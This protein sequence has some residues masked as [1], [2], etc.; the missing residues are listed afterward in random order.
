[1]LITIPIRPVVLAAFVA[2][3][4][5][6]AADRRRAKPE[7]IPAV[8][9][10]STSVRSTNLVTDSAVF[11]SNP[12][13]V[14]SFMGS[15]GVASEIEPKISPDEQA[16]YN[17]LR[18]MLQD[19]P[20]KA[21]RDLQSKI[22]PESSALLNFLLA[23]LLFQTDQAAQAI[24][25][26]EA[27]IAKFPNFRRA[28]KNLGFALVQAAEYERAIQHLTKTIELGAG[29]SGVFGL[30]GF[31]YLNLESHLS[32]EAAYKNALLYAPDNLDWKLGL[33]KSQVATA[34]YK[35]AAELLDELL[36]KHPEKDSLWNLQ[37]GLYLQME[38]PMKAALN[39]EILR[40]LGKADAKSLAL[41]G[42]IYMSQD[43]RDL[44]LPAYIDSIKADRGSNPARA[45]RAIEILVNRAAW[46]EA[47]V[48]L[49]EVRAAKG[50]HLPEDETRILKLEARIALSTDSPEKGAAGLETIVERNPLDA[51]ALIMLGDFYLRN[52]DSEKADF[53]YEL[54]SK[55]SG[56]EA[57]AMVK[58]AQ[59]L[60]SSRKYSQATELLRRAQ[61][62][63][64]RD[65]I[66]RYLEKIESI[67][68]T[69]GS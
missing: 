67:A 64:P 17:S 25:Q 36:A 62:I 52:G 6:S 37:A 19:D 43:E 40:K 48:L 33:V 53:R 26:Y 8:D 50:T 42:D 1:M 13:F 30:L 10:V 34:N 58:R 41:L 11:W 44:A 38:Q 16:Y 39:Y 35:P 21:A 47:S 22:R 27:A 32:A 60:V 18:P 51:E 31:S 45:F 61:K 59:L 5:I 9:A 4:A 63:N 56:F 49:Q 28:H 12:D 55:V 66:Q 14:K 15:Y 7:S 65:N 54:A 69:S 3:V 23:S 20:A 46:S 24:T 29:D 2:T 68:R 57:E